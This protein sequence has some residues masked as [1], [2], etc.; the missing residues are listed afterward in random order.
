[1]R[2]VGYRAH[3]DPKSMEGTL[4]M[5]SVST[6][7]DPSNVGPPGELVWLELDAAYTFVQFVQ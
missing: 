7:Y 4:M 2:R 1:M 6:P 5:S 3:K